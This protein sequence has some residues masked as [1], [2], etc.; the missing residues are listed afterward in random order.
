MAQCRQRA[1]PV[2]DPEAMTVGD[3][4][5]PLVWRAHYTAAVLGGADA[6][7]LQSLAGKGLEVVVFESVESTWPAAFERLAAALGHAS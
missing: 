4:Q 6:A 5:I 3:V 7:T 2:P 1:L